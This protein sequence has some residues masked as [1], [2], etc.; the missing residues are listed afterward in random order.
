MKITKQTPVRVPA[1]SR[2]TLAFCR[3]ANCPEHVVVGRGRV[4]PWITCDYVR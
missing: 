3:S 1:L 2:F 4:T